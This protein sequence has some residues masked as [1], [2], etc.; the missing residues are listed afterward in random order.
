MDTSYQGGE[1]LK[2]A[3]EHLAAALEELAKRWD[4]MEPTH[5]ERSLVVETETRLKELHDKLSVL[6]ARLQSSERRT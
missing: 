5:P 1:S 4:S 2:T 3:V 6:E